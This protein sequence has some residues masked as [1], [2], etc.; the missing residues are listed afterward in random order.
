VENRSS[1][2]KIQSENQ[3]SSDKRHGGGGMRRGGE[4][5]RCSGG[6]ETLR[7]RVEEEPKRKK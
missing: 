4:V 7:L 3:D 5:G 2:E 6:G 1:F